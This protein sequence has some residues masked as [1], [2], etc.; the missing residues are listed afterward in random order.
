M[1]GIK[2]RSGNPNIKNYGFGSKHRT[3]EQD[4]EYRSRIKGVPKRRIWTK[5]YCL[6]Q[7]DDI[8][9]ILKTVLKDNE[10]LNKDDPKKYKQ[11]IVM[12]MITLSNKILDFM[13]YL[14]PQTQE[15]IN[16]NIDVQLESIIKNWREKKELVTIG[17]PD[18]EEA[19][20]AHE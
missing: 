13:K 6:E 17:V 18:K 1:V 9:G 5:N 15:N 16:L 8:F 14:Y 4:N 19:K 2:G 11:E 7:L 10:K 3:K 20:D 12:D